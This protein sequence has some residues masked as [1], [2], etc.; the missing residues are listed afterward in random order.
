MVKY[1]K[2]IFAI[3]KKMNELG[4]DDEFVQIAENMME[5]KDE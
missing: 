3:I 5:K 4:T 2:S 1:G